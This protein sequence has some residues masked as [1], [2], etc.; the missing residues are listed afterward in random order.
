MNNTVN[1]LEIEL[2]N[3][4]R[5][6]KHHP[7]YY[8]LNKIKP[9]DWLIF[10]SLTW[11]WLSRRIDNPRQ[12]HF[13][14]AEFNHLMNVFTVRMKRLF[15]KR[16]QLRKRDIAY[17]KT[18]EYGAAGEMHVH[19]LIARDRLEHL[20]A[21]TAADTLETLWVETLRPSGYDW[22]SVGTAVV[23]PYEA[24]KEEEGVKYCL[25]REFDENSQPREPDDFLSPA[26]MKL[27]GR[28]SSQQPDV[29]LN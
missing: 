5:P 2:V 7:F 27:I 19:F 14:D 17:F 12:K 22:P 13:R 3:K 24:A 23:K 15:P 9:E 4:F 6:K 28:K 21:E 11:K 1:T 25:K 26:L 20:D 18:T 29:S 16:P 10:G 8:S